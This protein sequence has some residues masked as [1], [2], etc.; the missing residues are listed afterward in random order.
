MAYTWSPNRD[1][2]SVRRHRNPDTRRRYQRSVGMHFKAHNGRATFN[3]FMRAVKPEL[4]LGTFDVSIPPVRRGWD[5]GDPLSSR[6]ILVE[7]YDYFRKSGGNL[8]PVI[9]DSF[10]YPEVPDYIWDAMYATTLGLDDEYV[11]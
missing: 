11:Y 4:S 5:N 10:E 3:N 9:D 2:G 7:A 6:P 1:S 8:V